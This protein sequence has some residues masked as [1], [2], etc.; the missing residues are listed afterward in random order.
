MD[1]VSLVEKDLRLYD[2]E[3]Q[4]NARRKLILDKNK[5]IHIK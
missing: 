5:L 1:N 2:I 4:I 3:E